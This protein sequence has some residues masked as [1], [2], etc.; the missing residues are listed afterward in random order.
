M[1]SKLAA[2]LPLLL[3]P[4]SAQQIGTTIPEVHPTLQTQ[5][6]TS[7]GGCVTK[8]TSLVTDALSRPFHAAD[9]MAVSCAATPLNT[10]LCP[11]AATCSRN[12]VLEGVEYGS[13][14]V[15]AS[16]FAV[17]LRQF[18]FDGAQF[19]SVSPRLYLLA[20]DDKNYEPLK[21]INAEL[22][23]DVDVSKLACGMNGALY[24]SEMDTSGSRSD[25]NPAGAQY[26]TGYCDAQCFQT[27]FINGLPNL[28]N[29][30]ACCNEMDIWE[31]NSRSNALTPHTCSGTG[32]FLCSGTECNKTV[33]V[34]D[35]DGCGVNP[36]NLGS[37][38]F[39]GPGPGMTVDTS[40][41]FTVVTQFLTADNT[42]TGALTEIRRLYVQDGKVIQNALLAAGT[43]ANGPN[44]AA[45]PAAVTENFCQARN[46]S[47]FVRL[48]GLQGMG[49]ALA[50]G[51]VLIFSIWNSPGDFMNWL[52][53]G[54]AGPCNAT[55]GDPKLIL[56][57][58][59][60]VSVTF[61]NIR[62]GD[63]GST[64]SAS[65]S[66]AEVAEQGITKVV[67]S[68]AKSQAGVEG[69]RVGVVTGAAVGLALV[70][71]AAVLS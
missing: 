62:W 70:M 27:T 47:D 42:S 57:A 21:L 50:R 28:N 22:T 54:S 48:G 40:R 10:T 18:L 55:E 31:A 30:G 60:E 5:V 4:S 41:P 35:K 45:T 39:Y 34:C 1:T 25:L 15:L 14:G 65:L 49:Q 44:A 9:N 71:S 64:F 24:L 2:V 19:K 69:R 8:H 37:K 67:S 58:N 66:S 61:S 32:P 29:S 13:L 11:D 16:G 26:G 63:I 20:E 17:T 3:I 46:A 33:G 7:S 36:F 6:C 43:G 12:C 51:M 23:F 56:A 59:P 52:D 53:S 38:N 68:A